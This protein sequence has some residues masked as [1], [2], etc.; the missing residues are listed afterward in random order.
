MKNF[1]TNQKGLGVIAA[2]VII[3]LAIC[4]VATVWVLASPASNN[5]NP[6]DFISGSIGK[7]TYTITGILTAEPTLVKNSDS[8]DSGMTHIIGI[9]E[10][11]SSATRKLEIKNNIWHNVNTDDILLELNGK[12]GHKYEFTCYGWE[13]TVTWLNMYNYPCIVAVKEVTP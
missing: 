3:F 7:D 2:I 11:N 8:T 5:G 13:Q 6:K 9:K 4:C 1:K 12:V 10:T